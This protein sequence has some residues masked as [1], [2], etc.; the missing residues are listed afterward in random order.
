MPIAEYL[1]EKGAPLEICTASMLGRLDDVTRI[2]DDDPDQIKAVGGHGIALIDHASYSG[3]I[4]LVELLRDRGVDMGR[5]SS[6]L[7]GAISKGHL[8]MVEWLLDNGADDLT[9]KNFRDLT[10]LQLA[11]EFEHDA[12]AEPTTR[13]WGN[14]LITMCVSGLY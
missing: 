6:A 9:V 10:P 11:E 1:L 4:P 5:A 2:L 8:E 14:R 12:I 13:T 3:N 7:F